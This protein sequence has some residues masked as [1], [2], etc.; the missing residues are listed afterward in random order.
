[1]KN[2]F[3]KKTENSPK[4]ILDAD[5]GLIEFE[6]KCYPENTFDF[7]EPLIEW[8]EEY[9]DGNTKEK[10]VVNMKLT[11]FNSATTQSLFDIFDLM[12]DGDYNDLE[13]NWFYDAKN[14]N[15]LE[16][17]EDYSDEFEELNIKAVAF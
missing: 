14:E 15:G 8:L 4:I 7:F 5:N 3:I 10:T 17:F 12:Q 16:D 6:G 1:M 13:I 11:Y 9:F 2:I